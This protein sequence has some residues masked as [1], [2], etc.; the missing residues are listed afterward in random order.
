MEGEIAHSALAV[1]ETPHDMGD[2]HEWNYSNGIAVTLISYIRRGYYII[3]AGATDEAERLK[4]GK[5]QNA[6]VRALRLPEQGGQPILRT[7]WRRSRRAGISKIGD[8]FA[9][10]AEEC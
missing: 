3:Y 5:L 1:A 7:L 2:A 4:T 10:A 8:G 6:Q 9:Q